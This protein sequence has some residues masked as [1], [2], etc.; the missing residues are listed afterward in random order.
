MVRPRF[1]ICR[2]R[3]CRLSQ[4][5][6]IAAALLLSGKAGLSGQEPA[7]NGTMRIETVAGEVFEAE[8]VRIESGRIAFSA[9]G[10]ARDLP[11][12]LIHA[13]ETA[14]PEGQSPANLPSVLLLTGGGVF[15]RIDGIDADGVQLERGN[16][17]NTI[18]LDCVEAI[19]WKDS[20]QVRQVLADPVSD[21]DRIVVRGTGGS[22]VIRG[23]FESLAGGKLSLQ[24]E[25]QTQTVAQ[26]KIEAIIPARVGS[27]VPAD[28]RI[29]LQLAD[30][31]SPRGGGIGLDGSVLELTILDS[32][33]R[34]PLAEIR[35]VRFASDRL[36]KLAELEPLEFS[37]SV[38][39]APERGW[40][41]NRSQDGNP[42]T[43]EVAGTVR[44]FSSGIS[45]SP[46][47]QIEFPN[48]GFN[49][50]L[51]I[52]GIDRETGGR[53]DCRVAVRGDGIVLWSARIRGSESALSLDLDV[54]G[55]ERIE[56]VVEAGE[57]FDLA[58][59][60]DWVDARLIRTE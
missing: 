52:V 59:H 49:R 54:S 41:K 38:M 29:A 51:A 30:G 22:V 28:S 10:N 53:G 33:V 12:D 23:I 20:P 35:S 46:N 43:L 58:D 31:T 3:I 24:Y 1:A 48:A 55:M 45:M 19:V 25:G 60:V 14:V 56:L 4:A 11:L 7:P 57:L 17:P 50:F 27:P 2:F 8:K 9:A 5:A 39:F 40:K 42:L 26:E 18:A 32:R 36:Q 47:S 6:W 44:E 15:G 34:F 16:L 13:I 21:S 37:Q